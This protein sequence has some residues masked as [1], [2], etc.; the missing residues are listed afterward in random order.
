MEANLS[1]PVTDPV[2]E[3]EPIVLALNTLW[4]LNNFT[5]SGYLREKLMV[6][7]IPCET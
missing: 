3:V 7:L 2:V 1:I 4:E 5:D 6:D